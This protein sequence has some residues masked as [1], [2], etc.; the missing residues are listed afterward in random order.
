MRDK[1]DLGPEYEPIP[2]DAAGDPVFLIL[3]PEVRESYDRKISTC[4]AGWRETGDPLFVAEAITLVTIHRQT[5]P[6]WLDEAVYA[7]ATSQRT[8]AHVRRAREAAAHL[9][10][11]MAVRDAKKIDGLTWDAASEH[12]A[13]VVAGTYAAAEAETCWSSYKS[14]LKD[15]RER[16]GGLYATPKEQH[17]KPLTPP[18]RVRR[19]VRSVP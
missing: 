7:V 3:P 13:K 16:R 1:T 5:I 8:K 9:M 15:L 4:E 19:K 10:R 14:V 12:A 6:A 2:R 18:T 11:Y 17:R